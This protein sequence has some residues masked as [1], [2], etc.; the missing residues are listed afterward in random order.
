ME[1]EKLSESDKGALTSKCDE[2]IKWLDV[3]QLAKVDE[4]EEKQKEMEALCN[5]IVTKLHQDASGKG[6]EVFCQ[7]CLI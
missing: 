2:I 1:E 4:F 6:T 7:N 5:P 3:N